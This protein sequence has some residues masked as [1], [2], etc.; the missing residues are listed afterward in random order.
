MTDR[1]IRN[2]ATT[3]WGWCHRNAWLSYGL[4]LEAPKGDAPASGQRDIG[5]LMHLVMEAIDLGQSWKLVLDTTHEEQFADTPTTKDWE[6]IYD[7]VRKMGAAYVEWKAEEGHGAGETIIGTELELQML[8]GNYHGDDVYLTGKL[9]LLARDDATGLL[10]VED[11][12]TVGSLAR[13]KT[14]GFNFQNLTY[15]LLVESVFGEKAA[16]FRHLQAKKSKFSARAKPPFFAVHS[17]PYS[18]AQRANHRQ[19]LGSVISEMVAAFQAIEADP[20][21]HHRVAYPMP[22]RDCDWRCDFIEVCPMM[23]DGARWEAM[24]SEQFVTRIGDTPVQ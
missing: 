21:A 5:T 10:I 8:A 3:A 6:D 17:T 7:Q 19:H 15:G 18:D 9:D 4:G 23:D 2:S 24:L 20:N 22:N 13:P 16:T 14:L 12:K 1:Y 11:K